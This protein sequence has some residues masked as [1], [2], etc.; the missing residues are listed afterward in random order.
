MPYITA[1]GV[2]IPAA[3]DAFNPNAQFTAWADKASTYDNV[4]VVAV[5]S[6]RTSLTAPELREGL[7]VYVKAT[8]ILWSYDGA[9]WHGVWAN[10]IAR[11][12]RT[13]TTPTIS[14]SVF[15][16]LSATANWVTTGQGQVDGF[17]AYSNGWTVPVAGV[18][19]VFYEL[20]ANQAFVA[21]FSVNNATP[22]V[23]DLLGLASPGAVQGYAA[24]VCC[25]QYRL[26]AG[27]VIRVFGLAGAG[28]T[29]LRANQG[30]FGLRWVS[31]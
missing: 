31:A 10:A 23:T 3:S 19:E 12:V 15:T 5:D 8:E 9:D 11:A 24:A 16:D 29:V 6:D 18:Y 2:Q 20:V 21:G 26:T 17:A 13:S 14:N 25:R 30:A 7:L 4:L 1:S 22:A 28:G 27:Q